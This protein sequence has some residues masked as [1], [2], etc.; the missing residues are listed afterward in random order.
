[1]QPF[2]S[3][4]GSALGTIAQQAVKTLVKSAGDFLHRYQVQELLS[5]NMRTAAYGLRLS[6]QDAQDLLEARNRALK[7]F[8]RIEIDIG[9]TTKIID[10]FC[11]SPYL[12]QD[13][14]AETLASLHEVFYSAKNAAGDDISDER[15]L[16]A[17]RE[18]YDNL[19]G[20]SLE[21]LQEIRFD[22][23]FPQNKEE[24]R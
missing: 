23:Y 12:C 3:S 1:M 13:D 4:C 17:L 2:K 9:T 18:L 22:T 7:D 15:L 10:F 6:P 21:L 11:D 24:C 20:G 16:A 19:C 8:G 14:Y 5:T